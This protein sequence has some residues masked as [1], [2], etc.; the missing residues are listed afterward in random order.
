M[1]TFHP[2]NSAKEKKL[3]PRL[4]MFEKANFDPETIV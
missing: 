4:G 1:Y 3:M 2:E